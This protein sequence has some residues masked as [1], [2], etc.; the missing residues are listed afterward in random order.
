MRTVASLVLL[1]SLVTMVTLHGGAAVLGAPPALLPERAAPQQQQPSEVE[2]RITGEPGTPPRLAIPDFVAL[3]PDAA[4][5]A[6]ALAPVLWEDFNF[7]REFYLIPRDTYST[8]RAARTIETIPFA[9]WRELGADA[10]VFGTVQR[11]GDT[12]TI[13]VRLFNVRT[14]QSVFSK[15][16][17]GSTRNPRVFSHTFA[18][19]AHDQQRGLRGVARTK[20]TFS[21]DRD[22]ERTAGPLGP[23]DIKEIWIA[24]YDGANQR[25]ITTSRQLNTHPAWS[26]DARAVAYTSWRRVTPDIFVS[27]IYQGVM[28]NPSKGQGSNFMP[29]YSPDGSRIAFASTRAGNMEIFVMNADGSNA[30]QL[31][32]HPAYDVT[33][34][35]SPTGAQLAFTS[36]RSG[37]AQVYVMNAD[38]SGLRR[39]TTGESEADRATWSPAPNNEIAFAARTSA[40]GY[41]IKVY[42]LSTGQT[43]Q[44]TFG[45]GS[46]ESPSYAPNG[47]HLA[48]TSTRSGRPQVYTIGRD[49]RALRQV[50][51]DGSNFTPA[52]SN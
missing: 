27:L 39:L 31:T 47:R 23:R 15:E 44:L 28:E 1:A 26:P 25:R 10:L 5:V 16:Y 7:E 22:R 35:W 2:L 19:E 34:T 18:D 6:G 41:D 30:R 40:A 4:E 14:R 24:D 21:S 50:T 38:G 46:N 9:E 13:Q 29:V 33:P 43:R 49:G 8:I 3:S 45:E 42:E 32:N 48:F 11:A 12:V 20:L 36:D 51:R 52:W 17:T 37:K